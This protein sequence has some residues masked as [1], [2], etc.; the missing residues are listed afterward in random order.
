METVESNERK[1][2]VWKGSSQRAGYSR[3][4]GWGRTKGLIQKIRER[5]RCSSDQTAG[6]NDRQLRDPRVHSPADG[7]ELRDWPRAEGRMG[8]LWNRERR[9]GIAHGS[10]YLSR[11]PPTHA[12]K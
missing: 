6:L 5:M 12:V 10:I 2:A 11:T 1:Q 7:F 9:G 3:D 8:T 4:L